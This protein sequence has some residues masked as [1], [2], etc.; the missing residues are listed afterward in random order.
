MNDEKTMEIRA[1][2]VQALSLLKEALNISLPLL[3]SEQK[4]GVVALWE[5]FLREFFSYVKQKSKE[6]G[7]NL[8]AYISFNR[9]WLR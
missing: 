1:K 8:M 9:I 5:G 2:M 7:S 6:T 4:K 3:Q